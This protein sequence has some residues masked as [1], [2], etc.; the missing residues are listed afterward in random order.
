[1]SRV[2][3][4]DEVFIEAPVGAVWQTIADPAVHAAW[5]PFVTEISGVHELGEVRS[6]SVLIGKK[7]GRT[8]E[9]CVEYAAE[10][11]IVWEIEEDSSG[12]GKMVSE[13]RAGFALSEQDGGT[14]VLAESTFVPQRLPVRMML[15]LI[16]RKF[17]STQRSILEGLKASAETA[18]RDAAASRSSSRA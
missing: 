7:V 14:V 2:R 4:A 9:R 15:P 12:F 10:Q 18:S 3:I 8:R 16:R 5:H 11:R 17:H 1:M 6:C 13:W